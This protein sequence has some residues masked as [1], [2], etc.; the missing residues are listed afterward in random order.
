MCPKWL[1]EANPENNTNGTAVRD[2]LWHGLNLRGLPEFPRQLSQALLEIGVEAA[3]PPDRA[4]ERVFHFAF[5]GQ[6]QA[7][8]VVFAGDLIGPGAQFPSFLA[9]HADHHAA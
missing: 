8:A 9:R 6:R 2:I 3:H 5:L 4:E 7:A 1:P